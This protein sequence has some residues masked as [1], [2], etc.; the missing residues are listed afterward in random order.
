MLSINQ[1]IN[2]INIFHFSCFNF[3]TS[4][5]LHYDIRLLESKTLLQELTS[6]TLNCPFKLNLDKSL[7]R[8]MSERG[9]YVLEPFCFRL[10]GDINRLHWNVD[11]CFQKQ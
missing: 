2:L 5:S 9:H 8:Y 7:G 4:S 3:L 11:V 10:S 6:K 1:L